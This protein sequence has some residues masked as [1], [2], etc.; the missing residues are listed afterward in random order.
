MK[1][2]REY[3]KR[4]IKYVN[5]HMEKVQ[6]IVAEKM[7]IRDCKSLYFLNDLVYFLFNETFYWMSKPVFINLVH[8]FPSRGGLSCK[9]R[10]FSLLL[11]DNYKF[12]KI[13][14]KILIIACFGV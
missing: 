11:V 5:E 4:K 9:W 10:I 2:S 3:F 14:F 8:F 7:K 13:I 6:S 12:C 1:G